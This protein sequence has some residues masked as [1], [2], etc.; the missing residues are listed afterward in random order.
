MLKNFDT[1][2]LI[3]CIVAFSFSIIG[4]DSAKARG[5]FKEVYKYGDCKL[6]KREWPAGRVFYEIFGPYR[7]E[8]VQ[9]KKKG[10]KLLKKSG[11]LC[12]QKK[13]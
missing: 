8:F 3:S 7:V 9:T 1:P 12:K 2:I 5:T 10:K 11:Y 6:V 4:S 13:K